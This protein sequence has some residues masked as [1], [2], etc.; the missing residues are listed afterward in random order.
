[1]LASFLTRSVLWLC[2]L[3]CIHV[4][5]SLTSFKIFSSSLVCG[6]LIIICSDVVFVFVFTLL[7]VLWAI[8]TVVWCLSLIF[9]SF[10]LQFKL[11]LNCFALF[12]FTS[13]SGIQITCMLDYLLCSVLWVFCLFFPVFL[14]CVSLW[15]IP[16]E[17]PY[18]FPILSLA[19]LNKVV[20]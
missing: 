16:I 2:L 9:G 5:V 10:F 4:F 3:L 13:P 14:L 1:M 6:S 7:G 20:S 15:V 12:S 8:G 18:R 17:L 11:S 19:M